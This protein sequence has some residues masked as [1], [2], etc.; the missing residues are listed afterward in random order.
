MSEADQ[1]KY[2]DFLLLTF[3]F[4]LIKNDFFLTECKIQ[5]YLCS[6]FAW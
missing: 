2:N 3:L 1:L 5:T 6:S 4:I